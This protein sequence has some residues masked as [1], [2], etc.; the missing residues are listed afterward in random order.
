MEESEVIPELPASG[1]PSA[2]SAKLSDAEEQMVWRICPYLRPSGDDCLKCPRW[3]FDPAHDW[4]QRGCFALANEVVNIAQTGNP[5]R[6]AD[7]SEATTNG[8]SGRNK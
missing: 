3:T 4:V 6:R 2:P 5:W 7:G 8:D 1:A